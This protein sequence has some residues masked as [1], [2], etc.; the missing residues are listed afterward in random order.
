MLQSPLVVGLHEVN[1][2]E[3]IAIELLESR[4][5]NG[6]APVRRLCLRR[7]H[8]PSPPTPSPQ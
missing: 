4:L 5:N 1:A 8:P 3:A 2:D 6:G 7:E